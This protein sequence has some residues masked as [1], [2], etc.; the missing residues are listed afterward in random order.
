MNKV[1][2]LVLSSTECRSPNSFCRFAVNVGRV[3]FPGARDQRMSSCQKS[4]STFVDGTG[5]LIRGTAIAVLGEM[6]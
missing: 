3:R 2:L 6:R 5:E 4:A 1:I